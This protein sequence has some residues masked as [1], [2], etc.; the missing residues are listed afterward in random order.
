MRSLF[1][2]EA[3]LVPILAAEQG[4]APRWMSVDDYVRR[5][6]PYLEQNGFFEREIARREERYGDLV[7]VWSTYEARR[8]ADGEPF[9][10]GINSIQLVRTRGRWAI[11][12][13]V[14][15]A[16]NEAGPLPDRYLPGK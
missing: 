11:L 3:R 12:H 6:G 1:H 4:V 16:E 5:F 14:W 7:H 10:R 2:P 8:A 15:E 9:L 13:V